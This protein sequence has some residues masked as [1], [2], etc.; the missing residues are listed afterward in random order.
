MGRDEVWTR[1][2][3]QQ[4]VTLGW[5]LVLLQATLEDTSLWNQVIRHKAPH[6]SCSRW[7]LRLS[8][9]SPRSLPSPRCLS[10]GSRPNTR[11]AKCCGR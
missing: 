2:A 7:R 6:G 9:P 3:E 4:L 10:G 8:G 1:S 11:W 5:S